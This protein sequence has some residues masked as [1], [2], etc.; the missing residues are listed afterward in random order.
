MKDAK[1]RV[2]LRGSDSQVQGQAGVWAGSLTFTAHIRFLLPPQFMPAWLLG[3]I[4]MEGAMRNKQG[5]G[6]SGR[7]HHLTL[8]LS[9]VGTGRGRARVEATKTLWF[10]SKSIENLNHAFEA[11][12]RA[13]KFECQG[14]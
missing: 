8:W 9:L 11:C 5:E 6:K 4:L 12:E 3:I 7:H 2:V 13:L 1:A 10:S 14:P